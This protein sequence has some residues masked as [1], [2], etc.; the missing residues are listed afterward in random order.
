M[1]SPIVIFAIGVL[2]TGL[3]AIFIY[4]S[5]RGVMRTEMPQ[6]SFDTKWHAARYRQAALSRCSS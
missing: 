4:V 5:V 3:W 6:A 1:A 2:V